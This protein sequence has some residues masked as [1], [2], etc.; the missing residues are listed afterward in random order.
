MTFRPNFG[1][2]GERRCGKDQREPLGDRRRTQR[3]CRYRRPS[4]PHQAVYWRRTIRETRRERR[5]PLLACVSVAAGVGLSGALI[6][7][8]AYGS[9]L[10]AGL[11]PLRPPPHSRFGGSSGELRSRHPDQSGFER[12]LHRQRD[13]GRRAA[14]VPDRFRSDEHRPHE[15]RRG[16]AECGSASLRYADIDGQRPRTERADN[17]L[18]SRWVRSP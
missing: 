17:D 4:G 13:C 10:A 18:D 3:V 7:G 1:R 15:V 12:A 14:R 11:V 6:G 8:T 2:P 9:A 5:A 16:A